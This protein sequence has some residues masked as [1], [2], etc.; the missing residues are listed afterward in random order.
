MS[1]ALPWT[2]LMEALGEQR[3]VEIRESLERN[4]VNPLERD[5]FVLDGTVG[6]LLRDVM[7]EDAPAETVN[8][9][10]ALLHMLYLAWSEGWPV[11]AVDAAALRSAVASPRR[12]T[13]EDRRRLFSY[14][15]LPENLVWA[16]PV[17]GAPHEPVDGGF[18]VQRDE[19][20]TA[21]AVLGFR[22]EREGFTTA[23]AAVR[24]PVTPP[25]R[26]DGSAPFASRLPGGERAGL[27]SVADETELVALLLLA[28][29]SA[30]G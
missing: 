18:L 5:A 10:A 26:P 2:A 8:A 20:V 14:V 11:I 19:L 12:P 28:A 21:L 3:F 23:E 16:E 22:P 9:Y 15:Q 25:P 7:A 17:P 27:V 4:R 29:G 24:V 1:R 6:N 13:T 30:P